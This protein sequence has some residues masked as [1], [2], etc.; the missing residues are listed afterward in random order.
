MATDPDP[1]LNPLRRA[2]GAV[3]AATSLALGSELRAQGCVFA[4]QE[5]DLPARVGQ[6]APKPRERMSEPLCP[7]GSPQRLRGPLYQRI[8]PAPCRHTDA[9][10]VLANIR[11]VAA[12]REL[13]VGPR[14]YCVFAIRYHSLVGRFRTLTL[15][16][17]TRCG[18]D[19]VPR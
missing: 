18:P 2:R 5:R 4:L 13:A 6:L 10:N 19:R 1:R 9:R 7:L 3:R 12:L 17:P 11:V 8:S 15:R 16:L 14:A